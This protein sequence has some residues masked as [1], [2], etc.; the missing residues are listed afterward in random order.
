[1]KT[2][3]AFLLGSTLIIA[4]MAASGATEKDRP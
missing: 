2:L 3:F 4:P 1:M